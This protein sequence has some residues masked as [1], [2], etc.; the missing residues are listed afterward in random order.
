LKR[1]LLANPYDLLVVSGDF[2]QRARPGQFRAATAFLADLPKPHLYVPG[3]HDVPL[4]DVF[5]RFTRPM[6]RYK[7]G[8]T[9]DLRPVHRDE[10][11]VVIGLNTARAF[12]WSWHGFWKD[13]RINADQL[14]DVHLECLESP[15]DAFKVV[16]THHPFLPPPGARAHGVV[17]VDADDAEEAPNLRQHF[18]RDAR[19]QVVH[20]SRRALRTMEA[21]G[22]EMLMA[23]HLHMNYSGD[24]RSHHEAV[25][26][27]ILSIQAGTA[28]SH[29][30]RGEPNAYNRLLIETSAHDGLEADRLTVEVRARDDG[31]FRTDTTRRFVRNVAGWQLM[32]A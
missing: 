22:V 12:S 31:D 1:D 17:Q 9:E 7:R 24:V 8:V 13:G 16:V 32:P 29:R 26:R 4:H 5:T 20:G 27:S 10:Q 28:C 3:N 2:T 14:L 30:R 25:Q 6:S 18:G 15:A 21:V 11:L 19:P 23:G